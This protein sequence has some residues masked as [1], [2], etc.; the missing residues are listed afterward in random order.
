MRDSIDACLT[1]AFR[2][3]PVPDDLAQRLLAGLALVQPRRSRRWLLV[4]GG[5]LTAAASLLLALWLNA[6]G[7]EPFSQQY[8]LDQ[9]IQSFTLGF[10]GPGYSLAT[11]AAPQEYPLSQW[12]ACIHGVTWRHLGN[13]VGGSGVVYDLPG[14]AGTH[15]TLYVVARKG[16]ED[17]DTAPSL[18]P[19][20][21][22]NCN[23]SAWQEDGLLYVLVVQGD[24]SAYKGFLNLPRTPVA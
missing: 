22:A 19:Y 2:D 15:G 1:K 9:A 13:F 14:P 12:V 7:E 10:E 11:R 6:P 8:A 18:S 4:A 20:T 17:L 24:T 3:V 16:I 21:T 5:M 23:A